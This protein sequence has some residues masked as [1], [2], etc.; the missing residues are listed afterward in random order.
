MAPPDVPPV[1]WN[2]LTQCKQNDSH[3]RDASETGH[4]GAVCVTLAPKGRK[5]HSR[6]HQRIAETRHQPWWKVREPS[7]H[8]DIQKRGN[9][10]MHL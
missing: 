1:V 10:S 4:M 7:Y 5:S 8:G 6:I 3:P 9:S 2:K